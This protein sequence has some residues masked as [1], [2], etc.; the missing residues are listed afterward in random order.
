MEDDTEPYYVS[1]ILEMAKECIG[2]TFTGYKGGEFLMLE[3]TPLW[4]SNYGECARTVIAEI[5]EPLDG[6][7]EIHCYKVED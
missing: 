5:K 4:I 7:V 2:K 1:D 6:Y 3:D